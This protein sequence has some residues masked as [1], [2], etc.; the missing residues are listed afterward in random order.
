[1]GWWKIW[2]DVWRKRGR[3]ENQRKTVDSRQI[4]TKFCLPGTNSAYPA[5]KGFFLSVDDGV[6]VFVV[7]WFILL[8]F[9]VVF[10]CSLKIS[11]MFSNFFWCLWVSFCFLFWC[12]FSRHLSLFLVFLDIFWVF[13]LDFLMFFGCFLMF[14]WYFWL[15]AVFFAFFLNALA[16]FD[17][18][19]RF[20]MVFFFKIYV[21]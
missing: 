8:S 17:E 3:K 1:M 2:L 20:L 6:C 18:F 10:W 9:C 4:G 19:L 7:F 5:E 15:F 14:F 21:F 11:L 16:V 12:F 13:F